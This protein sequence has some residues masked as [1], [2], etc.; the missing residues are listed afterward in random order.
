MHSDLFILWCFQ[1]VLMLSFIGWLVYWMNFYRYQAKKLQ[2]EY[3]RLVS[4]R[5]QNLLLDLELATTDQLM[6]ELRD[7]PNTHYI[8]LIPHFMLNSTGVMNLQMEVHNIDPVLATSI[9]KTGY[10]LA[11][12]RNNA[13][14]ETDLEIDDTDLEI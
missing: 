5:Q 3:S 1:F 2:I 8:M 6:K 10:H 4:L 12:Q 7:R 14:A 11:S 9:I 13:A